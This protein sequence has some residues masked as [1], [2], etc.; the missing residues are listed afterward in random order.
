MVATTIPVVVTTVASSRHGLPVGHKVDRYTIVRRL[1]AGGFG[2][3]YLA[4][5]EKENLFAI[6]EFMPKSLSQRNLEGAVTVANELDREAYN[7]GLKSFF[8][9]G[10]VLAGIHHPNVV[11][12]I[13]FFRAN[14]TV[15]MVMEYTEGKSLVKEISSGRYFSER[16]LRFIFA[17]LVAGLRE[18]HA[19]RLLHLD[20]KPANVY[21]RKSDGSPVLLDF[22]AARQ[23]LSR[24][25][26]YFIPMYTPGYAAPE[27][28]DRSHTL[29]PWTDLYA[30]GATMYACI[31][32]E[33]P[34]SAGERI[35]K[36]QLKPAK[37]VF[38][39]LY[40]QHFLELIDDCM[41]V[42]VEDRPASLLQ[43]Q[44]SLLTKGYQHVEKSYFNQLI[45]RWFMF[46]RWVRRHWKRKGYR[47]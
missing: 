26:R 33:T 4:K 37:K 43:V 10:R 32:G 42:Y 41:S 38:R 14:Q 39:G 19:H 27:Q 35:K 15:Y 25:D 21:I 31:S 2:M 45:R 7:F 6:K 36:D 34:L 40:S 5:D 46:K 3:V 16:R 18:V 17:S 28:H 8:E 29:G 13:N 11:K 30:L 20:I 44:R 23:T 47:I 22:G 1:S 12:V 9:E 24:K